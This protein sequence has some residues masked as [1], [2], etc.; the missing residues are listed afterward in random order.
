MNYSEALNYIQNNKHALILN[1][2]SFEAMTFRQLL[3]L[4]E[5]Q[6]K[7]IITKRNIK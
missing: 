6:L 1:Q 2:D 5:E 7:T 4:Y 3:D